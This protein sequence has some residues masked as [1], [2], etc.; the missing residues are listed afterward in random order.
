MAWICA[1]IG[2]YGTR[3]RG[4]LGVELTQV[5]LQKR[6]LRQFR[7]VKKRPNRA[8]SMCNPMNSVVK[9]V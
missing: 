1:Y 9:R 8:K 6:D 3:D 2:D 4:V 7:L 5:I